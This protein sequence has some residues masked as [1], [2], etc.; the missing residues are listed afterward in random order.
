[1]Q[2]SLLHGDPRKPHLVLQPAFKSRYSVRV[3]PCIAATTFKL[4]QLKPS[5]NNIRPSAWKLA[6]QKRRLSGTCTPASATV[7]GSEMD[8]SSLPPTPFY[9]MAIMEDIALV[10][11][12]RIMSKARESCPCFQDVC[13][14]LKVRLYWCVRDFT[15]GYNSFWHSTGMAGKKEY[16]FRRE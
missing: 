15:I 7:Y 3:F 6:L 11:Q 13:I 10:P 4:T 8:P 2:L 14:L 12:F 16:T 1:M 5:K 9:N